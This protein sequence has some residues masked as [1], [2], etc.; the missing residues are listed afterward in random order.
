MEGLEADA[1]EVVAQLL[2][3]RLMAD[4]RKGIGSTGGR[5]GRVDTPLAVYLI[6]LLC[7]GVV[8]LQVLVADGPGG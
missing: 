1:C 4:R 3:A 8:G 6:E 7:F 5:L 2:D